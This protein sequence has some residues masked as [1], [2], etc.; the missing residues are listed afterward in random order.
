MSQ[1]Y[2]SVVICTRNRRDDLDR[3]LKALEKMEYY[4]YEV[5]VVDNSTDSDTIANNKKACSEIGARYIYEPRRGLCIAKNRGIM[6]ARGRIVAFTDDDCI[7]DK[8]W[9]RNLTGS[10]SDPKVACCT[11]RTLT[12][13]NDPL[14]LTFEKYFGFDRGSVRRTFGSHSLKLDFSVLVKATPY[15]RKR[16]ITPVAPAPFSVGLGNNMAFRRETFDEVGYF[17][18]K[19]GPGTPSKAGEELD[20][21]YR[22]LKAGKL[23]FYEPRAVIFHRHRQTEREL[24]D[25]VYTCGT[26]L[27]AFLKKHMKTGDLQLF[28]YYTGRLINLLVASASYRQKGEKDIAYLTSMELKGWINGLFKY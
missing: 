4:D 26:G 13:L 19:L 27:S 3:C 5:I 9:L 8:L 28:L 7:A 6:E 16:R 25:A 21:F 23:I 20:M 18:E 24:V 15:I 2:V 14:S 12:Y 17:D 10:F 22:V 1:P 11:G